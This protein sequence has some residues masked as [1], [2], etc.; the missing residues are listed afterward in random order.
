MALSPGDRLGP[1]EIVALT[2]VGGMGEVYKRE[3]SLVAQL[4]HKNICTLHDF[5]AT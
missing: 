5:A 4:N 3:A 1:C 2:G